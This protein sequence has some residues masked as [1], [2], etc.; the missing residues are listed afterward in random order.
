MGVDLVGSRV[1]G[2]RIDGLIGRGGMGAVYRA[3]QLKLERTVALKL[4]A[5]EAAGDVLFRERFK[6]ESL[7]AASVEHPNVVPIIEAD[8]DGERLFIAMRYVEGTD[9]ATMIRVQERLPVELAVEIVAQIAA[10]LAAAHERGLV[11]RDVKP[12]NILLAGP[13]T[14]P[15]VYLTDFGIARRLQDEGLTATGRI[16][17]TLEYIAPEQCRGQQLDARADVYALGCVLYQLVTGAVPYPRSSPIAQIEAHLY[18][19][20]PRVS[21]TRPDIPAALDEVILRALAK[22]PEDRFLTAIQL[23]TLAADAIRDP[24]RS[25][26]GTQSGSSLLSRGFHASESREGLVQA[27]AV[28]SQAF[29]APA[30]PAPVRRQTNLPVDPRPLVGRNTDLEV[31]CEMLIGD[32]RLVTLVGTG[33]VGKTHLA[34]VAARRMLGVLDGAFL[35]SL[36]G[37][38]E[39]AAL[40]PAVADVLGVLDVEGDPMQPIVEQIGDRPVLLILD[41]FEQILAAGPLLGDLLAATPD[42]RIIATSQAPLRISAETI[43]RVDALESDAAIELFIE[44]AAAKTNRHVVDEADRAAVTEIC[45]RVGRLPLGIELAAARMGVLAPGELLQRLD[46]S[47]SLLRAASRDAP[48]R[49]QSLRATLDWTHSAL[50]EQQQVLFRRMGIFAGPVP[51]GAVEAVADA[52]NRD[53]E[54][55]DAIGALE[56]LVEFSLVRREESVVH[57]PRFSMPQALREFARERLVEAGEEDALNH[58]HAEHVAEIAADTRIWFTAT[59]AEQAPLLALEEEVRPALTWT[60]DHDRELH[61][62]LLA[63]VGMMLARRGR[64]R[65]ASE[66]VARALQGPGDPRTA[67][68]AWL[69]IIRAAVLNEAGR[70]REAREA[71]RPAI[72]FARDQH[73]ESALAVA[74]IEAAWAHIDLEENDDAIT[75]AAESLKLARAGDDQ[76]LIP[77]AL[78]TLAQAI[79]FAG[80]LDEA[81]VLLNEAAARV[82]QYPPDTP[83]AIATMR[84]DIA[85]EHKQYAKALDLYA[86]SISLAERLDDVRQIL[87]DAVSIVSLLHRRGETAPALEVDALVAAIAQDAGYMGSYAGVAAARG[88]YRESLDSMRRSSGAAAKAAAQRAAEVPATDRVARILV[89]AKS[90]PSATPAAADTG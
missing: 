84:A 54:L 69:L 68:D 72:A 38:T 3:T 5:P 75:A 14:H 32:E 28:E 39:P 62:Q 59:A 6:R 81:E 71:L 7:I 13:Q 88:G 73:D 25:T 42:L 61:R 82:D 20:P 10:G 52:G 12:A 55:L 53:Q 47:L 4:I 15:H 37:V 16:L 1:G 36:A 9:L 48:E 63:S 29:E 70:P 45:E 79:I 43:L 83:L 22:N 85:L 17:G 24:G 89:L 64:A 40:L 58:L 57:G 2:Y 76:R 60:V 21:D 18:E 30:I 51:L 80:R 44:R 8:E 67:L 19:P 87:N 35:V 46:E 56:G 66:H 23:A 33:G 65:E 41:N 27:Q 86:E 49:H 34:L 50:A 77:K 74:L 26:I 78:L 31:L 11:H 90:H